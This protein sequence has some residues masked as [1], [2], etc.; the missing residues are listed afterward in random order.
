MIHLLK[1]CA[2]YTTK[3][4]LQDSSYRYVVLLRLKYYLFYS[5]SFMLSYEK[6]DITKQNISA[7]IFKGSRMTK[8]HAYA[9]IA[10]MLTVMRIS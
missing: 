4:A 10:F 6:L 2:T 9:A 1:G 7:V 5:K 8:V 3:R